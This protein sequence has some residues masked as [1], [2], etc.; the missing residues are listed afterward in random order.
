MIMRS[1]NYYI[2][3]FPGIALFGYL[4]IVLSCFTPSISNQE[5]QDINKVNRAVDVVT[6][7]EQMDQLLQKIG[8]KN[9]AVVVNP[10]SMVGEKHLLDTLM[11]SGVKVKKIFALEHGIRGD[12]DAGAVVEDGRDPTSGLEIISLY[13]PN[14]KPTKEN[15]TDIDLVL[16]DIQ[17]VGARFYT[18]ISSLHYIME[19]AAENGVSI[20][21]ADRPNPNGFYVD[22]PVLKE[23]FESFVGMHPVP[24]VHGM[25]V[26]EYALMIQGEHWI[27]D[28]EQLELAVIPCLNY[29]HSMT[30]DLPVRPS[31]NLP[32]LRAVLLYPS[33]CFF[34]G[35]AVSVGRGTSL[36]FQLIGSP[37]LLEG[38]TSFV[39]QSTIGATNPPFLG[40]RCH[41]YSF[42]G[43]DWEEI[44]GRRQIDLS[45]LLKLY[46]QFPEEQNFFL[47]NNFFDRLAGSDQ[48][49]KR[50]QQGWSESAI[51][52]EWKRDIHEFMEMRSNYLL[53]SDF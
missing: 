39:P 13:G 2:K 15:L 14:K 43:M 53:Y 32:N 46:A 1:T 26:G 22:G 6:G 48:L 38:D 29:D 34:E 27:N 24:V 36:Q 19:A 9:I 12:A 44:A 18:Y 51:R 25:T 23:G 49:R 7:A 8:Q 50:I 17:D 47:R 52:A 4:F 35:T 40:E 30:Y 31:P 20:L 28:A 37:Y 10:S 16:F 45:F 33:L 3:P 41:G 5:D 11:T 21:I 42:S